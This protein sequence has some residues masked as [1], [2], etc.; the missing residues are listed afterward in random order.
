LSPPPATR[1]AHWAC[2]RCPRIARG[3]STPGCGWDSAGPACSDHKSRD[4]TNAVHSRRRRRA[5]T[6]SQQVRKCAWA[7]IAR[8]S[9]VL[10]GRWVS[11]A[12]VDASSA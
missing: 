9:E 6:V 11:G 1:W 4:E 3:R 2:R 12:N 10:G 7:R 5:R 8:G